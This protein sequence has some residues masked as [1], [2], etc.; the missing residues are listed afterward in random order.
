VIDATAASAILSVGMA[1]FVEIADPVTG[2]RGRVRIAR[3][4]AT[5]ACG[6]P[7]L[8]VVGG[9]AQTL[10]SWGGHARALARHREVVVYEARGQGA[11]ELSLDDV[12]TPRHVEDFAALMGALAL[13][14]PVDLCGFSLGGRVALAV[15]ATRGDLVRRLVISGV[16]RDETAAGTALVRGWL[17]AL[18]AGDLEVFSRHNA[19]DVFGPAY[20]EEDGVDLDQLVQVTARRNRPEAIHALLRQTLAER[21]PESSWAP[22]A[23]AERVRCPVLLLGGGLDRIAPP[24][25][26]QALAGPLRAATHIFGAVGHTIPLEAPEEWR[27]QVLAF[28]DEDAKSAR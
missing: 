23:L 3:R 16:G 7:P 14:T 15:A 11:T 25:E 26:I 13:D 12:S 4:A 20:L 1:R 27:R 22:K 19:T 18:E 28:L 24:M 6:A 17:S 2:C 8:V 9:L 5:A 10:A 21:K